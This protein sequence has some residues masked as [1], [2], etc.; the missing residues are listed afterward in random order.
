METVKY[1]QKAVGRKNQP[2]CKN[3][4]IRVAINYDTKKKSI[5]KLYHY[6]P[7][8]IEN[9]PRQKLKKKW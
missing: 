2:T 3:T 4:V 5:D 7:L 9:I 1:V 6:E 8:I